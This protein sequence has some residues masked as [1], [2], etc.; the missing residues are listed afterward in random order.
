[1]TGRRE[2]HGWTY[3]I[4]GAGAVKLSIRL[5]RELINRWWASPA[6]TK[7]VLGFLT[8]KIN[9]VNFERR[10]F[11]PFGPRKPPFA[12]K[13]SAIKVMEI[14]RP[15][16][17]HINNQQKAQNVFQWLVVKEMRRMGEHTYTNYAGH[18][19]EQRHVGLY[20]A[21][22]FSNPKAWPQ[23]YIVWPAGILS[24]RNAEG[25]AR[26][27]KGWQILENTRHVLPNLIARNVKPNYSNRWVTPAIFNARPSQQTGALSGTNNRFINAVRRQIKNIEFLDAAR[28]NGAAR[29][30]QSSTA[31]LNRLYRPGGQMTG[32]LKNRFESKQRNMSSAS[33]KRKR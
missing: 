13:P 27:Q 28:R 23:P 19:D 25:V 17:T 4:G 5:A 18:E 9:Q 20:S 12:P 24:N 14:V 2:G 15:P 3:D 16:R 7:I 26:V 31:I 32:M 21:T 11:V 30:I 29:A 1:L 10:N 8:G 22:W 6:G 33:R